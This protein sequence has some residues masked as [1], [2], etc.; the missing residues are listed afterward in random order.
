MNKIKELTA[1]LNTVPSGQLTENAV[2]TYLNILNI[3]IVE[4]GSSTTV[5]KT[6]S[7]ESTASKAARLLA[8]AKMNVNQNPD[9]YGVVGRFTNDSLENAL[10]YIKRKE[11]NYA[12]IAI[13]GSNELA[14]NFEKYA[15]LVG[16]L[17]E[18]SNQ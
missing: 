13:S 12:Y 5:E 7:S 18:L 2:G 8:E 14:A 1:L 15:E 4:K 9:K 16:A 17:M 11:Y 6:A 10:D 3:E